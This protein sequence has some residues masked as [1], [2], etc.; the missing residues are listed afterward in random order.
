MR[1]KLID[2]LRLVFIAIL[3]EIV[4]FN[5]LSYRNIF[6]KYKKLEYLSKD[7]NFIGIS[8][9]EKAVY[10]IKNINEQICSIKISLKD[11]ENETYNYFIGYS[12]ETTKEY[13]SIPS[14]TYIQSVDR[15]KIIPMYL[16][17]KVNGIRLYIDKQVN[18]NNLLDKIIINENIPIKFNYLR[19][20]F[21]LFI[22]CIF[23]YLKSSDFLNQNYSI[24]NFKQEIV[25][26]GVLLFFMCITGYINLN[27]TSNDSDNMYNKGIVDSII[28]GKLYL[29]NDPSEKFMNLKDPYDTF[30]RKS[31][32]RAEDYVWDSAYY[33]GH[34]YVYFGILPVILLFLPFY[35][36]TGI[37]LKTEYVVF[38]FSVFAL[39]LLKEILLKIID[40]YFKD[41]PFKIVMLSLIILLSGSLII[42]LN[43]TP[44]FY[45]AAIIS[46]MYFVLQG[47][48]FI[49]KA[50]EDE[51]VNNIFVFLGCLF[52]A[53]SVAC[54]PTDL[55]ASFI[56]L[57]TL[58]KIFINKLKEL[59]LNSK[60]NLNKE[61]K[62]IELDK[63][64]DVIK[65]I[66]SVAIPYLIVG[67]SLMYYNYIR[68]DNVFEFGAR[69][70]L[71][72]NNMNKLGSRIF[73]I[74]M[75]IICNLF[76]IPKIIPNF[77]FILNHNDIL[78]F[79]GYYYIENMIGGLFILSPI[80][81]LNICIHK[82]KNKIKNNDLFLFIVIL[83]IT[84]ITITI[85]SII[86]AGSNQRYLVDYAWMFI[87]SGILIFIS[88]FEFLKTDESKSIIMKLF[89]IIVCYTLI[90]NIFSGIVSES[91]FFKRNSVEE[92]NK[93]KYTI[94]FWE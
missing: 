38:L 76:S 22:L 16:S 26:I 5:I 20:F 59:K 27:C 24:K 72:I 23:K 31:L 14:K 86:N 53:L 92:Y 71:T 6:G 29:L 21:V 37:Y 10:E 78:D 33:N 47:I 45:E 49:L 50:T 70:Q 75:G 9:D 82:I 55:I 65:F 62:K 32:S 48:W 54:R 77:P 4:L 63:I 3:L 30:S 66:I 36:I 60:I 40:K 46:G 15:S 93:L 42:Y 69:Y 81:F 64:K 89:S 25:L 83:Q 52:L 41:I 1:S 19:F 68:F 61:N 43:G 67:I 91:G 7:I 74:P 35:A 12:D 88:I 8:S 73:T 18:G 11:S 79:N 44:I 34:Q 85:I 17:G 84:A 39:I 57:P 87:L 51:K 2:F 80:C 58:L 13:L 94:C 28:N 90:I 56:I